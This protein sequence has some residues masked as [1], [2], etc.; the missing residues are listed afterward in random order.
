MSVKELFPAPDV[1]ER[2]IQK[3]ANELK[4]RKRQRDNRKRKHH[5][6]MLAR[7]NANE[8]MLDMY[9]AYGYRDPTPYNAV[10]MMRSRMHASSAAR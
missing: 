3:E 10:L 5:E 2:T 9:N 4:D 6:E 8:D 7:Q 1:R